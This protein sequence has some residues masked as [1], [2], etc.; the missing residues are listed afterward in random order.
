MPGP[1][2]LVGVLEKRGLNWKP[3]PPQRGFHSRVHRVAD[4]PAGNTED[5]LRYEH[6]AVMM[7]RW[8]GPQI[9]VQLLRCR[10]K[11]LVGSHDP[12]GSPGLGNS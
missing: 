5:V 1:R 4:D 7:S 9:E 12:A 2:H 10:A 6:F 8:L 3:G 11:V